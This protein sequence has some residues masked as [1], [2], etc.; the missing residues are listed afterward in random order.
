MNR[1]PKSWSMR[2]E[3]NTKKDTKMFLLGIYII[4]YL[5]FSKMYIIYIIHIL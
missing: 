5:G 1:K 4:Y 3:D 2:V